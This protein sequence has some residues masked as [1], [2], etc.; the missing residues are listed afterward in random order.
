MS[1]STGPATGTFPDGTGRLTGGN[2]PT[3]SNCAPALAERA[4]P[5]AAT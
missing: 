5:A 1:W 3:P 2:A 4:I